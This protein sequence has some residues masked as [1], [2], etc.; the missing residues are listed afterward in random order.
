[1]NA[2]A[3]QRPGRLERGKRETMG[4]TAKTLLLMSVMTGLLAGLGYLFFGNWF[5]VLFFLVIAGAFNI[6][7]YWQSDKLALRMAGAR[8][9]TP[10]QEPRLHRIVDEVVSLTTYPK[11]RVYV[12]DN[13]SPN[14]FATS[15]ICHSS[16]PS[17][18]SHRPSCCS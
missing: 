6:F 8:E 16:R 17:A 5:G 1:M 4:A 13:P 15:A 10:E 18:G 2:M 3:G 14:A 7:A 11:P 9:V 12:V